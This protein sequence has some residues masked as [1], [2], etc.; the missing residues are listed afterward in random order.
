MR[1]PLGLA[2]ENT[3]PVEALP[4][5]PAEAER[6]LGSAAEVRSL[7]GLSIFAD[8]VRVARRYAILRSSPSA[9]S[10]V[11]AAPTI[12]L[13]RR[14]LQPRPGRASSTVTVGSIDGEHD[15]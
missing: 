11:P 3:E 9:S 6:L 12:L 13:P 1:A 2:L 8:A 15:P 5:A 4:I 7:L 10:A 14:V